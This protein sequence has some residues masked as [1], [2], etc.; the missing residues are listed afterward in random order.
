MKR[1]CPFPHPTHGLYRGWVELVFLC[2]WFFCFASLASYSHAETPI[3]SSGLNTQ[4]SEPVSI[5]GGTQYNITGGTR[6]SGGTNLFHSFGDFNVPTG[7]IANFLNETVLQTW[8]I[9]GRVTG[10]NPSSIFGTIQTEGFGGTNLFLMNPAGIVFGPSA[11]LHVGG[12]VAFTTANYLR[13]GG[14]D[15]SNAGIFHA[16]TSSIS[17]LTSASVAAFGFL[18]TNP[19][20]ISIQGIPESVLRVQPDQSFSLVGGDQGFA[21]T[22]PDTGANAS[23]SDGISITDRKLS[24]PSGQINLASVASPGEILAG[25]LGQAPNINGQSFGALGTIQVSQQSIIDSS[26]D[27]GGTVRIRSGRF[28]LEES[29]ISANVTGRG[30]ITNRVESIGGGIDIAV[31]QDAVIQNGAT[32][33]TSV[34]GNAT[35]GA[36]YGGVRFNADRIEIR[37]IS[38]VDIENIIL[39]TIQSNVAQGST[40]GNSGDIKLEAISILVDLG[41]LHS[42][43]E[44]S[45]NAGNIIMRAK[46]NIEIQTSFLE[47]SLVGASGNAGSVELTSTQG[48]VLLTNGSSVTSQSDPFGNGSVG[49]IA[50]NAPSGNILLTGSPIFGS[51]TLFTAIDGT[52]QAAGKGGIELTARNMTIENSGI[53]I[54]N[55]TPFRPGSLTVNLTGRLSMSGTGFH[56]TLLTT[57]RTSSQSADVSVTAQDIRLTDKSLISTETIGVGSGGN[58]F[59]SGRSL[60]MENGA[61]ISAETSGT[62]PS[63][64]GGSIT[65][66]MTDHVTMTGEASITAS[67]SGLGDSGNI[68]ISSESLTVASGGRIEASTSG[69]GDGGSIAITTTGDVTVTGLS[70]DGQVR[71][72]IFA[73]TLSGGGGSGGGSGGGGAAPKPGSAGD[74]TIDSK[75]LLLDVGA[76]IDSSTT[77]GGGGG[78]VSVKTAENITIAGSSTRLTSDATRGNGK[79]GNITL[80]AKNITVHDS[81]SVTA[82][83]GGKGDAGNV[84][85]TAL[86]QLL[87]Q[88]AGTITTSTSGSGKGGTIIIQASQV[89]LDGPGT[90]IAAN[91]LRPFADMTIT[92]DILHPN[93]GDLV[94][95]LDSPTGTR[96]ALLSRIGGAGD[97]F[98]NTRFNDQATTQMTSTSAP[99]TGTFTPREPLGQLNNELVAGNWTLN[100][101]DQVTDNIGSLESW[102]LQIGAQTFQSTGGSRV[103]PDNGNVRSTITVA[104][105]TVPTVQA[106]GEP[107]GIGGNITL[108]AGQSVTMSDGASIT[109]SSTGPGDAGNISINAG[110]QF[111][112]RDSSVTTQATKASGGN[113]D[114]QAIDRVRLVNSSISTSVLGGMGSGGNITI[115]PDVVVLQNSQVIAQAAQG[116][117]GNITIFTPLFLADSTS[118]VDAS[119]QFGVN[120]TVTIQSPTSNLSGSLGPLTSKP[121]QA[122]NI[123]TQRCAA[124]A[125]GQASSFVVAGREQLPSDPGGWL[126]SPLAFAALGENL[127]TGHAASSVPAIMPI[128]GHDTGTVSLRRLTPAGFLMANFS[129]SEATGCRS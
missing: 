32:L 46:G 38:D 27:S 60:T 83:T 72:G 80:V 107:A 62:A 40:G 41:D 10:G 7:N 65:V 123:L 16:E 91:T 87:L 11:T 81:A 54:D 117:G 66:N 78:N 90:G 77:S 120:G 48:D 116:A 112:M 129:D 50:V 36:Q 42:I 127:G 64:T 26:G 59:L 44:G 85:L 3:T 37:G 61:T 70:A 121:S 45:G 118:L 88:S 73:K 96:V 69:A 28:V 109:A 115:D 94:V 47:S 106:V 84:T 8:N 6:P 71:S 58:T 67:S 79:G 101:R 13:L 98:T 105:P 53:Q 119:S 104:N 122:Q 30:P 23:V 17:L 128:A 68:T 124:L 92:I 93:D 63:A 89:L 12:S 33:D 34:L 75:N 9:L 35:L 95:Q 25:T 31:S 20:A 39:T 21:Y 103:I 24:A 102:T 4:V 49:S 56:S 125:N 97:N 86:D 74:I 100:V 22:N 1:I 111:E 55:F 29:T 14:T 110:Q 15:G 57:T 126:T 43:T 76:Q 2:L 108:T 99:F 82:A 52:G 114:V 5:N 18:G 19:S 51:A 113:I